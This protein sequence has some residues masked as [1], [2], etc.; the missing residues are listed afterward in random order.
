MRSAVRWL[1]GRPGLIDVVIAG[2]LALTVGYSIVDPPGPAS[3]WPVWSAWL[4]GVVLAAPV[5]VRR[6]WPLPALAAAG[7]AATLATVL[8]AVTAGMLLLSFAPTVL[9][10]Y[11]VACTASRVRSSAALMACLITASAAIVFF[12]RD[13][14]PTLA[15]A[16]DRSELPPY[17]PV[18]L[19]ATAAAMGVAWALGLLVR[20]RRDAHAGLARQLAHTAVIEERLRISRELHDLIG[21]SMSLIAVKATVANH[22][23]DARPDEVRAALNT[24]EHTSRTTLNEIR[25]ILGGLRADADP[26]HHGPPTGLAGLPELADRM[27]STGLHVD[28]T[29]TADGLPPSGVDTSVYRI[30]QEALTN[31][32]THTT[33]TTC[34]VTVTLTGREV[35][36]EVT[37]PGPLRP[38]GKPAD[39]GYGLIGMRERVT[40]YGGSFHAGPSADGGFRVAAHLP[41][42][43]GGAAS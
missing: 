34:R 24:I 2:A 13:V 18:E 27:R 39:G 25:R 37:D 29:I 11:L 1:G 32:T 6:R 43:P 3:R 4:V 30:V 41:F 14:L 22:I 21:H 35:A 42:A 38:A 15:P 36:I 5:S 19:G 17:W 20:A 28:L 12:Y 23:A 8:G 40:L 26:Y 9:V 7:T 16:L 33:A 10:L 31:V